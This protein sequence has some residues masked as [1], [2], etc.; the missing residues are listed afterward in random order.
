MKNK[1]K[2]E[3]TEQIVIVELMKKGIIC[4][5]P[6]GDNQVYDLVIELNSKL[7]KVQI[8]TCYKINNSLKISFKNN[9]LNFKKSYSISISKKVDFFMGYSY[10]TKKIYIIDQK[11]LKKNTNS[12]HLKLNK[13]K[14]NQEKNIKKAC[15]YELDYYLKLTH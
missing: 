10:E 1:V 7:Y 14:N 6:L 4:S 15:Y 13:T 11:I 2:G 5:K 8:R 9:R 3:L 12:V